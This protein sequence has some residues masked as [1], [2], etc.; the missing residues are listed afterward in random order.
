VTG[1]LILVV[2]DNATTRKLLRIALL[3]EGYVVAEA[4]DGATAVRLAAENPPALVLLDFRLPDL[5]GPEVARQLRALLP[6]L[7]II[8]LTGWVHVEEGRSF[9]DGF[10]DL[11]LK[12]V[13]PS[14]VVEIVERHLEAAAPRAADVG[15]RVLVVDDHVAQ[16]KLA[17]LALGAAG[18]AVVTAADGM[19]ALRLARE[20][21][22]DVIVSDVLMLGMDGFQVCRAVRD[23][24]LLADVPV[25]LTS[26]HFVEEADH[27][28]AASFGATRYVSRSSGYDEVVRATMAALD[29]PTSRFVAPP[30]AE[31]QAEYFRRVAHQLE[32]QA[33]IALG[34]AQR[35]S[36]QATALSMLEAISNALAAQPD[37][38]SALGETLTSCLDSAGMSVGAI[39]LRDPSG[40]L[41]VRAH[42]GAP[43]AIWAAQTAIVDTALRLGSLAIPSAEA[44]AAGDALLAATQVRSAL[45]VAIAARDEAMG[46]LVLASNRVDFGRGGTALLAARSVS[47]QIGQAVALSRTFQRLWASERRYRLLFESS[48]DGMSIVTLGGVIL[49]ANRGWEDIVGRPRAEIVGRSVTDFLPAE[50]RSTTL[51]ELAFAVVHG[52]AVV[53]KQMLHADGRLVQVELSRSAIEIGGE[54]YLLEIARDV[55]ERLRLAEQLRHAQK[56]DAVGRLAGGVAHDMNNVLAVVL[57]YSA[58]LLEGV[59]S[60]EVRADDVREIRTA[61]QRGAALTKQLLAFSRQRVLKL[62]LLDLNETITEMLRM[63][64]TLIGAD[65]RVETRLAQDLPKVKLDPGHLEQVIM[66]LAINAR[67]AMPT[68]GTLVLSTQLSDGEV[69]LSV[70]DN[71][72]GMT[73]ATRERI[74]EPFFTTKAEGKGTGLG[75]AVVFGIIT[76]SAGRIEVESEMGRGT[77]FRIHLPATVEQQEARTP[78]MSSRPP[79]AGGP[80]TVL[81]V[82]DDYALRAALVRKLRSGGYQVLAAESGVHALVEMEGYLGQIGLLVTDVVLPGMSGA[83]L[84]RALRSRMP[85]LRVLFMSGYTDT[86]AH[87]DVPVGGPGFLQKPFALETFAS[88]VRTMLD[89]QATADA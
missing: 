28:L 13:E 78:K 40:Q 47:M 77:T 73:A 6:D 88:A 21:R 24:P 38:E 70:A 19:S 81:L 48:R 41:T 49:E 56:M 10:A 8:G 66:N 1:A 79:A 75:L 25:V 9:P 57:S 43:A 76:Q 16:R 87:R 20:H 61:A 50:Q 29:A 65:V 14:R 89:E 37:P 11:L 67:D 64:R 32:R 55:S 15:K 22:P 58:F 60:G 44:G 84:A 59:E 5:D 51:E 83:D 52:S 4:G 80:E 27:Q 68:G 63:V 85:D 12:P 54:R 86:S 18:F 33:T 46:V 82:E 62:G 3:A 2:D 36:I 71:G 30:P 42:V 69:V 35:A 26:A 74:F 53:L 23:D 45:A 7:P 72:S 34:L 17:R 31:L 39:L